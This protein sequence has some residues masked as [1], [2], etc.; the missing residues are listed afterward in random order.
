MSKSVKKEVKMVCD[1]ASIIESMPAI[2]YYSLPDDGHTLLFISATCKDWTGYSPEDYYHTPGSWLAIIHPQDRD[3]LTKAHLKSCQERKEHVTGYRIIHKD[4]AQVRYVSDRFVPDTDENQNV[5]GLCGILTDVTPHKSVEAALQEER[6][7]FNGGPTVV[8]KMRITEGLPIEYVSPNI[9]NL[10]GYHAV[11]FINGKL[12]YADIMHPNDV[13]RVVREIKAYAEAGVDVYEQEYR[14]VRNDGQHRWI[15]DYTLA[16]RNSKGEVTH[17]HGYLQDITERKLVREKLRQSE[18]FSKSLLVHNPSPIIVVNPDTS[19]KY[20]NPAFTELTGFDASEVIS[21]KAPYPWWREADMD[22]AAREQLRVIRKGL[23]RREKLFQRKDGCLF[24][25]ETT[26]KPVTINKQLEYCVFAWNDITEQK[27]LRENLR[28]YIREAIKAQEEE[29]KRIARE[30]HDETVQVLSALCIEIGEI[31]TSKKS[32]TGRLN[33]LKEI[34]DRIRNIV[35]ELRRFSNDLRPGLLDK[36]GLITSMKLLCNELSVPGQ[37]DAQVKVTGCERRLLSET[38]VCLFRIVQEALRNAKKHS[39]GTKAMVR[40]KYSKI[41]VRVDIIDNGCGFEVPEIVS[42]FANQGK[43]GL[44]GMDERVR[45]TNSSLK[46]LSIHGKG[47]RVTVKVPE[48]SA[49]DL[50]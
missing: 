30:L 19:I 5:I 25:V 37:F 16:I 32:M 6:K 49:Y 24:W 14:L 31:T 35:E 46:I 9:E 44:M 22:K 17:L 42:S 33:Q 18:E 34:P 38:E 10:F 11:D 26:A 21:V 12:T 8:F 27:E 4:T 20:I 50:V 47:T 23:N 28:F 2:A 15:Q 1:F 45:F 39:K 29:R 43:L 13:S 40:V 41:E 48:R 7:L 36:F 3:S